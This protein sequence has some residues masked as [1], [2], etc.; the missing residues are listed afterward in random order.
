MT[1]K[2]ETYTIGI[3]V[4]SLADGDRADAIRQYIVNS[5]RLEPGKMTDECIES[6]LY[7]LIEMA[8]ELYNVLA[9]RHPDV[10]DQYQR[11]KLT[12]VENKN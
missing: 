4:V 11:D 1:R 9:A 7:V 12:N 8:T 6:C 3:H 2:K 10:V 5:K